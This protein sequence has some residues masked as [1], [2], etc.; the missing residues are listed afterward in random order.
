MFDRAFIRNAINNSAENGVE[1][2]RFLRAAG[3]TAAG[4]GAVAMGRRP[5]RLGR[6]HL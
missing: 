1:R 6:P 2:R 3:L 4:V 5:H